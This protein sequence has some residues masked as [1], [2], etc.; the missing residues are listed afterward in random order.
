[1]LS[2]KDKARVLKDFREWT[3]GFD[4]FEC[5]PERIDLYVE[6][7]MDHRLDRNEVDAYLTELM[8]IDD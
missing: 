3:G 2:N 1:M 6:V 8:L 5:E 4:P 7:A